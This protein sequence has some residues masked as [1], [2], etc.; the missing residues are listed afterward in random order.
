[1]T[2]TVADSLSP[3]RGTG[4][5]NSRLAT[6]NP[7]FNAAQSHT[8]PLSY[9][10]GGDCGDAVKNLHAFSCTFMVCLKYNTS[11]QQLSVVLKGDI[12]Q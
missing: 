9:D 4:R 8:S 2:N 10:R 7:H 12:G 3:G 1:M 5:T 11:T 6:A